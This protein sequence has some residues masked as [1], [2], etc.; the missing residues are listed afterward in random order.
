MNKFR[1]H[2]NVVILCNVERSIYYI[3]L[4]A[5]TECLC[6]LALFTRKRT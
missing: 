5:V 4:I 1:L 2:L 3:G 6:A